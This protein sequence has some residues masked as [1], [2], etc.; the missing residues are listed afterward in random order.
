L[1]FNNKL[2]VQQG[3]EPDLGF[4]EPATAGRLRLHRQHL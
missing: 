2:I 4:I 1:H 3:A